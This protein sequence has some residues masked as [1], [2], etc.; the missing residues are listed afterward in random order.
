MSST[1]AWRINGAHDLAGIGTRLASGDI[2]G[3]GF[4]DV[5]T[6]GQ[7]GDPVYVVFGK[8]AGFDTDL[9]VASLDG[10]NGFAVSSNGWNVAAADVNGDGFDDVITQHASSN[11]YSVRVVFG[12]GG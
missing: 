7:S 11:A 4:D 9:S 3:D 12:H 5:I 10:S 8:A 2:N 1:E 6:S